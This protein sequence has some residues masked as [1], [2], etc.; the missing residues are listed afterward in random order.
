MT[1]VAAVSINVPDI[2][3][4]HTN[5]S[6]TFYSYTTITTIYVAFIYLQH[7]LLPVL[8]CLFMKYSC[9]YSIFVF[10]L[11][12][13]INV[14]YMHF[15]FSILVPDISMD[16]WHRELILVVFVRHYTYWYHLSVWIT[17]SNYCLF[18]LLIYSKLASTLHMFQNTVLL[19][20][21][22]ICEFE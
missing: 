3:V 12:E 16:T 4:S 15:S 21:L 17:C 22:V 6:N 19:Y 13:E 11:M 20:D 1:I 10:H 14:V 9:L 2:S 18:L 8:V 7:N 5:C